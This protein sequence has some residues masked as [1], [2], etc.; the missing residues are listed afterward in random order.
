MLSKCT[1]L[2]GVC[3][4]GRTQLSKNLTNQLGEQPNLGELHDL[5]DPAD[6]AI[7]EQEELP[8][9]TDQQPLDRSGVYLA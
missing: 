7:V 2:S 4:I 5:L 6:T 1:Y 8:A 3:G 9:V